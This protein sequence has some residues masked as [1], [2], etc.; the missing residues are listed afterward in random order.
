MMV[1][2]KIDERQSREYR[3]GSNSWDREDR[4][5]DDK[6]EALDFLLFVRFARRDGRRAGILSVSVS[7]RS[8]VTATTTNVNEATGKKKK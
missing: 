3:V 5:V 2:R 6:R 7:C 8:H 1:S 4:G